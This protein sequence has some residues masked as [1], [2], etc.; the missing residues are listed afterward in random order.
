VTAAVRGFVLEGLDCVAHHLRLLRQCTCETHA[1]Y[2]H[3]ICTMLFAHFPRPCDLQLLRSSLCIPASQ[4]LE[5]LLGIL[6]PEDTDIE[7]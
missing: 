5:L 3:V 7:K 4:I 2:M 1:D 6:V